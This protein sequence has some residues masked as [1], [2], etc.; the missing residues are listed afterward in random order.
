METANSHGR[1][2]FRKSQSTAVLYLFRTSFLVALWSRRVYLLIHYRSKICRTCPVFH[3][4]VRVN[5][6]L[7]NVQFVG[8]E[9][10]V[11]AF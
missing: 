10:V 1:G 6:I 4:V 2:Q 9:T 3:W 5:E 7:L 8:W 11:S